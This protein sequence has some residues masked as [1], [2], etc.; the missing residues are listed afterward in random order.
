[1]AARLPPL[2][3]LRAFEVAARRG[4]FTSA[5][6]ELHVTPA[7]VSHQIKTLE[8]HLDVQLFRRLPRGLA[9]T[10]TGRQ[11]L[12]QLS[13]GF[14]HFARAV[15]GLSTGGLAGP[16]TI[17]TAPSVAALWLVP[18]LGTF[19]R[20]YPDIEIRV[21]AAEVAP[22]LER[23]EVDIRLPY[24]MGH[25]PGLATTLI[26]REHIFPVC[27]PSLL[28]HMRLRRFSDLRHHTLLHDVNTGAEEPT[29]TWRRWLRDAAVSGIDPDKGVKFGN[30][31]LMVEAAV[32]GFGVALGRM[33]LVG[34]HLAT[35][36]LVRPLKAS[37]PADYAYYAVTTHAG[38]ERPRVQAFLGW[39]EAQVEREARETESDI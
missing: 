19:L 34:D 23:G 11:L 38:A 37:R 36:R 17:N 12:P 27:A 10:E 3:A 18:R 1:M 20:A 8:S 14:E 2:N 35:G 33:S 6:R 30:S 32:R 4:G 29:M 24:G 7:A 25:Y 15:E 26:M 22:D 9:L 16:L 21:L 39:L 13:R 5:A 31:I 28:N